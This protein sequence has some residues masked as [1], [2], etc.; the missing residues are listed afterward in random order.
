MSEEP[1]LEKFRPEITHIM[2]VALAATWGLGDTILSLNGEKA[3]LDE[4]IL[5]L[6][7]DREQLGP[8]QL[9]AA[10]ARE[11]CGLLLKC[12]FGPSGS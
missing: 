7:K 12:G 6:A 1:D 9:N 4:F 2:K 3:G 11:L 10:C 8:F 5:L